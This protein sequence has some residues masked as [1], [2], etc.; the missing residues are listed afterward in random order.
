[1]HVLLKSHSEE[2]A[3]DNIYDYWMNSEGLE[4]TTCEAN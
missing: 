1:M 3:A 4:R 2:E